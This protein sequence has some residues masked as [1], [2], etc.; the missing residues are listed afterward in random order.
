VS[1]LTGKLGADFS[2]FFDAVQKAEVSLRSF[3]SGSEKVGAALTKM[4]NSFSGQKIIQDAHLM[5]KA[6]EDAGGASTLTAKELARV[7]S[8]LNE[9]I[10]KYTAL[11]QKAPA[12]MLKLQQ[13][14]AKHP[15][16]IEKI[17]GALG[18]MGAAMAGAFTV[19]AV[20]GA[21][22]Q[23]LDFAGHVTDLSTKLGISTDGIQKFEMA[24]S[25]AGISIDTVAAASLKLSKN[26]IGDDK[27]TVNALNKMGLSVK[28][29]KSLS[30]EDQFLEVAD[31]VG[32]I[33]NPTEK[34][35]AAMTVFGKGGSDLLA[36]LTGN[37]KETTD[38]FESMGLI[39]DAKTI[40]AADELGDQLGLMG[41]QL[42]AIVATVIGPLLPAI[43][44]LGN[45]LMWVG[46]NVIG[47]V[48]TVSIKVLMTALEGLWIGIATLLSKLADM[49]QKI[50]LVGSHL[51][52]LATASDW[53]KKSV[54]DTTKHVTG[55]WT[56]TAEMGEKSERATPKLLGLGGAAERTGDSVKKIK[57]DIDKLLPSQ[58]S[59]ELGIG[60]LNERVPDL[61]GHMAEM[62][63][64]FQELS[65]WVAPLA[66]KDFPALNAQIALL[67]GVLP[68]GTKAIQDATAAQKEAKGATT[69]WSG[70]LTTLAGAFTQMSQTGG[71]SFGEANRQIGLA[72]VQ[73][74]ALT[75]AI[76]K[77]GAAG[78]TSGQKLQGAA[79]IAGITFTIITTLI[80][81]SRDATAAASKLSS[82]LF[83][84]NEWSTTI[85]LSDALNE[86]I[87]R[88]GS[89][90]NVTSIIAELGGVTNLTDKQLQHLA[91]TTVPTLFHL[92]EMGGENSVLAMKELQKL[93]EDLVPT[94]EDVKNAADFFGLSVDDLGNKVKQLKIDDEAKKA[95]AAFNLLKDS[96]V[97]TNVI[98]E[99]MSDDVRKSFIKMAQDA[100]KFGLT[101]P[102]SMKPLLQGL[103]ENGDL[104]DDLA[105]SSPT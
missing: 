98:I 53:L 66:S 88:L 90:L 40:A 69:D 22:K 85:K 17:T 57:E 38:G 93:F 65:T 104:V 46:R 77:I 23:V 12:A 78:A 33:Q 101:I 75:K 56:E 28:E 1:V 5:T 70:A 51:G 41:K 74:D 55:L 80:Q 20:I 43:T 103:L 105:I 63:V 91:D 2:S 36:G 81:K 8:T 25:P 34:A 59:W 73:A 35:Y 6:V 48:L 37:L 42:M 15:S 29:L 58:K 83:N 13:E 62:R 27:A 24:F 96:G 99:K 9:A 49:A 44:A 14:T 76:A 97:D 52:G 61:S 95:A 92:I 31:A 94:F 11:G 64:K 10:E 60:Q 19:G 89:A 4:A 87:N 45:V 68:G 84:Q 79:D 26:L 54:S 86:S 30:P 67:P 32:K 3:E 72:I 82:A 39:I 7:N 47:P 16:L 100:V 71:E 21:G 50:P 102:D 18:P